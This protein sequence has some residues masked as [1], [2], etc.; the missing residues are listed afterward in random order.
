MRY[1]ADTNSEDKQYGTIKIIERLHVITSYSIV[2]THDIE[3]C[4]LSDQYP[5]RLVNK[6]FESDISEGVLHLTIN[7][8]KVSAKTEML[9]S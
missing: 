5:D 3:V 2:A 8:A 6:C 7:Y 4:R 9:R 1:Y